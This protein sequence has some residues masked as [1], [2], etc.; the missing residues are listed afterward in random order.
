MQNSKRLN[1][2][3][4]SLTMFLTLVAWRGSAGDLGLGGTCGPVDEPQAA[5]SGT[6]RGD[7][8]SQAPARACLAQTT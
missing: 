8:N 7:H 4:G 2:M 6:R 5:R 1:G 3:Q